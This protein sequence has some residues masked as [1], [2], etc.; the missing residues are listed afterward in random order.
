M[1]GKSSKKKAT[2]TTSSASPYEEE[3]QR[4][5]RYFT[6][7]Q[8]FVSTRPNSSLTIGTAPKEVLTLYPPMGKVIS[9]KVDWSTSL[10]FVV[11]QKYPHCANAVRS[12][13]HT[14]WIAPVVTIADEALMSDHQKQLAIN[15]ASADQLADRKIKE[16]FPVI[17]DLVVATLSTDSLKV[18]QTHFSSKTPAVKWETVENEKDLIGLLKAID[19]S[20]DIKENGIR[21]LEQITAELNFLHAKQFKTETL[22]GFEKRIDELASAMVM[23]G[24][25]VPSEEK[26]TAIMFRGLLDNYSEFR[27]SIMNECALKGTDEF[28]KTMGSLTRIAV[29]WVQPVKPNDTSIFMTIADSIVAEHERVLLMQKK[30][31]NKKRDDTKSDSSTLQKTTDKSVSPTVD[32]ELPSKSKDVPPG[33]ICFHC[34]GINHFSFYCPKATDEGRAESAQIYLKKSGAKKKSSLKFAGDTAHALLTLS[35]IFSPRFAET[36]AAAYAERCSAEDD[37]ECWQLLTQDNYHL[38]PDSKVPMTQVEKQKLILAQSLL[39]PDSLILDNGAQVG[40]VRE[41]SFLSD[42]KDCQPLTITGST[43]GGVLMTKSGVNSLLGR[44]YYNPDFVANITS[45]SQ[46][47]KMGNHIFYND[48]EDFFRVYNEDAFVDFHEVNGLYATN[49]HDVGLNPNSNILLGTVEENKKKFSKRALDMADKAMEFM[50]G[51][52]LS[53]RDAIKLSQSIGEMPLNA[54]DFQRAEYIY[55][56]ARSVD[57]GKTKTVK[58]KPLDP[59]RFLKAVDDVALNADIMFVDGEPFLIS[60]TTPGGYGQCDSLRSRKAI[61]L[62]SKVRRQI[63]RVKAYN[64]NVTLVVCDNEGAIKKDQDKL[65]ALQVRLNTE[66]AGS[67][68]PVIENLIKTVKER[69]R[70]RRAVSSLKQAPKALLALFICC[71][72]WALN[73]LP[74]TVN[75]N[76]IS[77]YEFL[78]GER[79]TYGRHFALPTESFCEVTEPK[80]IKHS[81]VNVDRTQPML[82]LNPTGSIRGAWRFFNLITGK[83]VT[84]EQ[85]K[86]KPMPQWVIDRVASFGDSAHVDNIILESTEDSDFLVPTEPIELFPTIEETLQADLPDVQTPSMSSGVREPPQLYQ[87]AG[88]IDVPPPT[89]L[90]L[91]SDLDEIAMNPLAQYTMDS[92]RGK[93]QPR[94]SLRLRKERQPFSPALYLTRRQAQR[95]HGVLPIASAIVDEITQMVIDKK[96]FTPKSKLSMSKTQIK[97]AL[98]TNL[99]LDEKYKPDGTFD[100]HKARLVAMEYKHLSQLDAIDVASPTPMTQNILLT[101][102]IAASERREVRKIDVSGAFLNADMSHREQHIILS[103]Q[104]A[105]IVVQLQ[106]ETAE[107]LLPNGEMYCMLNKALYGTVEASRLWFDLVVKTLTTNGFTQNPYDRCVFNKMIDGKQCTIL[108]HVDDF[109]I[110]SESSKALDEVEE[111]FKNAFEKFTVDKGK[112]LSFLGMTFD[113]TVEDKVHVTQGGYIA[114]ILSSEKVVKKSSSPA[115]VD[116]HKIDEKF[117]D[118]SED[119]RTDFHSL[120]YK[121]LYLAKRTR[122]DI[123]GPT[124]FLSTR[125]AIATMQ[126]NSKLDRI[127]SYLNETSDMGLLLSAN[128]P[129]EV[130][131]YID[132]S[133]GVHKDRRGHTGSMITIGSGAVHAGS[134]SQSINTKSSCECELVGL[135]DGL[136]QVIYTRNFLIGQGYDVPPATIMQDNTSAISLAQNGMSNSEKT[137]H[138]SIRYFF[139]TDRI[140]S[141]EVKLQHMG[142]E[143]MIADILTKPLQGELFARF[144]DLLLGYACL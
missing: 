123:L 66:A 34:R 21:I 27:T 33:Y 116:L 95:K 17:F 101:A 136:S 31:A 107:F 72:V 125:V 119:E 62:R 105:R 36:P 48:V 8:P 94:R 47:K 112:V 6:P 121:L 102:S 117:I 39:F 22:A 127:L 92:T 100:K 24:L 139:V 99:L 89:P 140:K 50:E 97:K 118:L 104:M 5:K 110:T 38:F 35:P 16:D 12:K 32:N 46:Q 45:F 135:S 84:R 29:Q 81:D 68:I 65:N 70:G 124:Q 142:T 137:R 106:P 143:D 108:F 93:G 18:L 23:N 10:N 73:Y 28:P 25:A 3:N 75:V 9:N 80:S 77:P 7:Y 96:V 14:P 90:N 63:G 122:P 13:H 60:K 141:G 44:H 115:T 55:G 59:E 113:F 134:K 4:K 138:I 103:K 15:T 57:A 111:I 130:I 128:S 20:H 30:N 40:V 74:T 43:P 61:D 88:R 42:I 85:W 76:N 51:H 26:K 11:S 19:A 2:S 144:R 53:T 71:I 67:H 86:V 49:I 41:K 1:S 114:D 120:V 56:Q 79:P 64:K 98:R 37:A 58:S 91:L 129:K 126:D 54:I 131:A 52:A 69:E 109:F 87:E 78:T 132:A 133:Y 82:A 83:V